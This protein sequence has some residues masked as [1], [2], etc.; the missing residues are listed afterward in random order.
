MTN[1][2]TATAPEPSTAQLLDVRA[3]AAL[4]DCSPRHVYR[5]ADAGRMPAPVRIGALVRWRRTVLDSW[6]VAG[7][8]ATRPAEN[9]SG[10]LR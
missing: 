3:V 10:R 5:L 6:L 4:L 2:G 8:P 1:S 9:G 7:C